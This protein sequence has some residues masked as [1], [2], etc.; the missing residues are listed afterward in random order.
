MMTSEDGYYRSPSIAGDT[1]A[2]VSEDDVW[3]VDRR[4]GIARRLTAGWGAAVRPWLSPDG[5]Y[6]A[7]TGK[8]EGDTE[9]YIMPGEG[10]EARRL[11]YWGANSVVAGYSPEG[12]LVVASNYGAPFRP[13][14]NLYTIDP[15]G[16]EPR[17]LP[18]GP[19]Q[20]IGFGPSGGIVL[21]RYTADP[22]LW[23]R[24]RGGTAGQLWIDA[25]GSGQFAQYDGVRGNFASPM[26]IGQRIYFLSD[27]EGYGN[28]YSMTPQG[29]DLRRHTDHDTYYARN[30]KTDGTRIVYHAGANLYVFDPALGESTQIAINYRSQRTQREPIY[31]RAEQYVTEATANGD[32]SRVAITTRGKLF[33]M[34]P[35]EGPVYTM[36]VS[37]GVRYRLSQWLPDDSGV[38]TVSDDGGEELLEVHYLDSTDPVV[39]FMGHDL[40]HIETMEISPDGQFVALT[41]ER[42]ELWLADLKALTTKLVDTSSQ[43]RMR[44]LDWSPDS[45]WIAYD[46]PY[47]E[48]T[49][50]I[51]LYSLSENRYVDATRPQFA[52]GHPFFDPKGRYLYFLSY[53]TFDPIPDT[54]RFDYNFIKGGKPYLIPLQADRTSPFMRGPS[55][56]IEATSHD[57]SSDADK[58][59]L[60]TKI[61]TEGIQDRVLAFSVEEGQYRQLGASSTHVFWTTVEPEGRLSKVG[62]GASEDARATLYGF[63]WKTLKAE[64]LADKVYGFSLNRDRTLM[65][66]AQ[67]RKLRVLKAGQKV[68]PKETKPGKE[69]GLIDLDRIV[70]RVD[71]GAEWQQM[72]REAWRLMRNNFWTQNMSGTDWNAIYDRYLALLP[73]VST[74][75]ELS[76]L[77]W[78]MQG[79]LGTSHA[80]EMGGDYRTE[81]KHQIGSLA[82]DVTWD[83]AQHGYRITHIVKGDSFE[84]HAD[85]PLQSPGLNVV[86]GDIIVSVNGHPVSREISPQQWLVD[87]AGQEV[88]LTIV[89]P[90]NQNLTRIIVVK[91]L[92]QEQ[93]TRYREWVAKNRAIVHQ[94]TDN[95]V[96][97]VHIPDMGARGF[98]EFYRAYLAEVHHEAL[99]VDIRFNGG[100]HVSPLILQTLGRKRIAYDIPRHGQPFPYPS[101]SVLGPI[102]AL[103]NQNAGS[104]GDIFSKAFQLM[105][106]GPLLGTRTWG[107][108][109]GIDVRYALVDGSMTSQPEYSYWFQDVGWGVENY[110]VDPDIVVENTPQDYTAGRDVQLERTIEEVLHLLER[111][112]ARMPEFGPRPHLAPGKLPPRSN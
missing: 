39:R 6:L 90:E 9:I 16:G 50:S 70:L 38:V 55:P 98:S 27:H 13:W 18:Y 66:I 99:I 88:A 2:F 100:G 10:G 75:G 47:T 97:Y 41:N 107:G 95:R 67:R 112:P 76:D 83:A 62:M 57:D 8:E 104:D 46:F 96:G 14:F 24:Y 111:H 72:L 91:P 36:G 60:V 105:K 94:A 93:H 22:A 77:M 110:G 12:H 106:L 35:W 102:V 32:G 87:T 86:V 78:E 92:E 29:D 30:A 17:K 65:V 69:S 79:E 73:R 74:R 103:T 52:D 1:V 109:I 101:E 21:G 31:P 4:G 108:V 26:W 28:L 20:S 59:P 82:A 80:Y 64:T 7:Y 48:H 42:M 85:S 45:R 40:G 58:G 53:R 61:D 43:A 25:D 63:E 37:D 15:L 81:P 44:S 11:T 54:L 3:L 51:R 34:G 49:S 19:A 5:C 23:K 71:R 68:D 33:S 84:P 89:S 56:L